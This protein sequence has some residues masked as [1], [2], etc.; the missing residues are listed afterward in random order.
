MITIP[1]NEFKIKYVRSSGPGGQ[2]VN[3]AATKAQLRWNID[4]SQVLNEQQKKRIRK[5]LSSMITKNG[6]IILENEE[7]R[8]QPQNKAAVIRRLHELIKQALKKEKKRIPTKKSKGIKK[9]EREWRER[10]S[11]KKKLRQKIKY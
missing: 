11:E 1:E 10:H 8:S 3:K 2:K 9:R 7:E 4:D 6:D 5:K